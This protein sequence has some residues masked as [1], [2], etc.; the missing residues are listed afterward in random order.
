MFV[1]HFDILKE[2]NENQSLLITLF[3][4]K[5]HGVSYE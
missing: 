2:K 5:L 4:D 1:H 3:Y